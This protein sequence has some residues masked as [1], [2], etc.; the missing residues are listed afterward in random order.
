MEYVNST[1]KSGTFQPTIDCEEKEGNVN[2]EEFTVSSIPDNSV[3]QN[4]SNQLSN[5]LSNQVND[6]FTQA[7]VLELDSLE[8]R[9][10]RGFRA[11]WDIGQALRQIRDKRLYRQKYSTFEEYCIN[12]WE[13]AR[14]TAYQLIDAAE[15]YE[16]VRH[17][18]QIFPANERQVR[19]LVALAPEEQQKVWEEAVSTAP[20]G[21]ITATHVVKVAKEYQE[22]NGGC[23]SKGKRS[24]NVLKQGH[25]LSVRRVTQ[26]EDS[27]S[28]RVLCEPYEVNLRS[29]WNCSHCSPESVGDKEKFYC[30]K[31]GK[32]S[33]LEKDGETR[34][35][36]CEF[37]VNR[38]L[39][40]GQ[41]E[42]AHVPSPETIALTLHI[43]AYL[44]PLMQDTAKG[45]GL[46]LVDWASKIL[47]EAVFASHSAYE[48]SVNKEV[49]DTPR[50]PVTV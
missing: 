31:L 15:V 24:K 9:V 3:S 18:A 39:E 26:E 38:S 49:F 36:E 5:Q 22:R 46:N 20:N 10:Q 17:G 27:Q 44:Q 50:E 34:A 1:D 23:Q 29:C 33:F 11:F 48:V 43:P 25:S 4:F 6:V 12:R 2:Q 45:C 47:A 13:I 28:D 19:P 16:N 37:W 7:E 40:S 8:D 35:A 42:R 30:Y 41:V 32:L 21:K 14:R